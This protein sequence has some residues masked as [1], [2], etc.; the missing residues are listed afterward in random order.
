MRARPEPIY[1]VRPGDSHGKSAYAGMAVPSRRVRADCARVLVKILYHHRT[2]RGDAQGV[3]IAEM[4][5][6]FRTRGHE[7]LE[8]S[9]VKA[10]AGARRWGAVA[11]LL[12]G[13]LYEIAEGFYDRGAARWLAR[14]IRESTPDLVYERYALAM[15]AGVRAAR[16]TGVPIFV[17]VNAPLAREKSEQVGLRFPRRALRGEVTALSRADRVLAVSTPLRR[18][19]VEEGVPEQRIV[20]VPNGV[21]ADRFRPDRDGASVRR[22][23]GIG[24]APVIGFVGWFRSWHG[25]DLAVR[26]LARPCVPAD[27]VLLLVGDGPERA[28]LESLAAAVGAGSRLRITGEVSR[29][30]IPDFVAAFDVAVQPAATEYACPMKLLEYLATGRAVVAPD[31]ENVRELVTPGSDAELFAP[32]DG[33]SFASKVGALLADPARR[34]G[35]GEA[36]RRGI[37]ENGRLWESNARRVEELLAEVRAERGGR[38]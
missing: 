37:F 34:A 2:L 13:P 35:L 33:E 14:E 10:D 17:E 7:V 3:H 6:A 22:E 38:R 8:R 20:V 1:F 30:R 31:Q 5:R 32:R 26:A 19:L 15:S 18:I 23:L 25:L 4:I 11:K 12:R 28:A 16:R 21:D 24:D 9:L 36:A 27:A 29:D